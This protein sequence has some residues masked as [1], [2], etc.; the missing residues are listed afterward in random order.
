MLSSDMN[1]QELLVLQALQHN[2]L[3]SQQQIAAQLGMS[4]ESV[5]GHIMRLTRKGKIL[6]KGYIFPARKNVVVIGGTN[7][8]I[9]GSSHQAFVAGDSNPGRISQTAGGVARNIAENLV[10][11]GAH[12]HLL[13]AVG[14]DE[15]GRWLLEQ[16]IQC[17]L[18]T[19]HCLVK[20]RHRTGTYLAI[21]NA[22]GD[23]QG[24]VADMAVIDALDIDDLSGRLPLLQSAS[25]IVVEAN[26]SPELIEW[27]SRQSFNCPV[28]ADAVSETKAPRLTPLLPR[29]GVLKVNRAEARAML[30]RDGPDRDIIQQLLSTG[31]GKIVMSRGE[32]GLIL[33]T[34]T[35][36][37]EFP[38]LA[39]EKVSDTGAGDAL[40]AG[41]VFAE[42]QQMSITEQASLGLA[43]A[44]MT[45]ASRL[46]VNP[47]LNLE[48]LQRWIKTA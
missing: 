22:N 17:G 37:L 7:V 9:S 43:C 1:P 14:N 6:G 26:C 23:L 45:M 11:L 33:A 4:R 48:Q 41:I 40:M 2:P 5:A 36:Y 3:A 35:D 24:A 31:A 38:S 30:N 21:N 13:S 18:S 10:R 12:T 34:Q 46:A 19:E 15:R 27:M 28:S 29:L 47:E 32:Q 39:S 25:H 20:P 8:D 16:L 42:L 44:A